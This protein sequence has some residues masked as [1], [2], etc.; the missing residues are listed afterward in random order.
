MSNS[1]E[2]RAAVAQCT[3]AIGIDAKATKAY[4]IRCQAH[5]KMKLFEEAIDDVKNAIKLDPQNKSLLSEF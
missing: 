4:F 1:G 2:L 3:V 5:G